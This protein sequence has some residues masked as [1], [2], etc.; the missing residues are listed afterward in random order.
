MKR[1]MM[2][3][4]L[5]S[6][7]LI[8]RN[9]EIT[10]PRLVGSLNEFLKRGGKIHVLDTGSTDKTAEVARKLGCN[11][12]EVGDKFRIKID[13]E[14]ADK[15][16]SKFVIEGEA[17]V[18]N[19]G[20]SLFDF[21]SARNYIAE[22]ADTDVISTPDCD[23]IFTKF[24]IDKLN[25]VIADGAEQLEYEFVF[26]H[27]DLGNPIIKFRHCKFY[28]RKK[29]KW[30]GVVHEVLG[31]SAKMVYLGEDIIKLEHY[32]NEKTNRSGYLKGL[33]IDCYQNPENDR[34]SHYFAR[35][36]MYLGRHK[37][38]IREFKNHISMNRWP[39]EAAQSMM[40]IGDC[41]SKLGDYDEMLKWY[42]KSVE[43]EVRRE[44][45]MR[46]AEYYFYRK[47]Y[48]QA[49]AY[50]EAALTVKQ[51]PFYSNHQPYYE[52]IPHALL[53][54]AYWWI[55]DKEKS[56]EHW[57][58]AL[59]FNPKNSKYI[60]DGKFYNINMPTKLDTYIENIKKNINF[61][62]TKRGDG[63]LNCMNGVVGKNCD[64][65]D[66]SK[67]LGERLKESFE[68]LKDKAD[69]LEW[70][71]QKNY[72]VL[73][74]RKDNNLEKLSEFYKAIKVSPRRKI[75]VGPKRLEK[76][77]D[78]L[79]AE[80]VEVPAVNAFEYIKGSDLRP[81]DN[82]IFIFSCGMPAKYLIAKTIKQN[83]NITCI[84]AGS[85]FDPIF[86][87]RTRTEQAD[88]QT[89]R[90]LYNLD[91]YND[92]KLEGMMTPTELEW[93][94][95]TSKTVDSFL[96]IGSYKG[97]STHAILSGGAKEVYA[98]DH[99]VGSSDPIETGN[100]DT[101]EAFLKNVGHFPNLKVKRMSSLEAVKDFEDKSL[102]VVFIDGGHRIQEITEDIIA[103]LPKAKKILCG[104]DYH[105]KKAVR[106]A[107]DTLLGPVQS[108]DRIWYKVLDGTEKL[109]MEKA[110][111]LARYLDMDL[112]NKM[113]ALP[114][115]NHP[116]KLFVI[117]NIES[118]IGKVIYDIGCGRNKTLKSAIGIDVIEG[119]DIVANADFLPMVKDESADII[120]SRH[121]IEHLPDTQRLLNEW[122]RILKPDG[123]IIFVL[124]DDKIINT[125]DPML[126][127]GCHFQAFTK[128]S[129][130]KE[131]QK[132]P[133]LKVEKIVNVVDGWSFG[134]VLVKKETPKMT[135]VIPTLGR[136]EGL[137][138]CLDSISNLYY[139][140]N[141]IEVIVKQDSFE[142]RTGVPK[143]LKQGVEESTGDWIVFGSNDTEFSPDSINEALKVGDKG[144]VSF[145]TG[146][147]L[148][149]G[150]NRN[151]HFMIRKDIVQKIGE[152][153]DT[154]YFHL[155]V[156][157]LLAAKMDKLG[158]FVRAEK[159]I[160]HHYHFTKPGGVF[161]EVYK[162][163]WSEEN[164]KHDR[165]LLKED[166]EKL[167]AK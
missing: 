19:E 85:A 18:V 7:C 160:V 135:F 156:D 48:P 60:E 34:N 51:L 28:N 4:P 115:E 73:L 117:E 124:P 30:H 120:I 35:E 53:Y 150:G 106:L 125:L 132:T 92:P 102:D 110:N 40:F 101:Y 114:Q 5:F 90:K 122:T 146:K 162:I 139:P 88:T 39:T 25:E 112:V 108:C 133:G 76:V 149:D 98:V 69:V 104:H 27:D 94:Y 59:S 54:V 131:V 155:G 70:T 93:L 79:G 107:V 154:R 2:N 56:K 140:K 89:L 87:G 72:N 74:H 113:F 20:E 116:E 57:D 165:E 97:K 67:E 63:E 1:K 143:L 161:D 167:N 75:F 151:E 9:E 137:K 119:S 23:E 12:I 78:F 8:A 166:L 26:S 128:D 86:F 44:P 134:G 36:M 65:H 13:K 164:I 138:R 11:V 66:Y 152:I 17:P 91:G 111:K 99:F 81:E 24:D 29:L 82:D 21:A 145:N 33:A 144:F 147:L 50:L 136:P 126:S 45:L 158:I 64:G 61:T 95:Q 15:V 130:S 46:L 68:F 77:C 42:S 109:D 105:D 84:D 3:K 14:L 43:K 157:N 83:P 71:D 16:N 80:F 58:K 142:N 103:W 52:D 100:L 153:F 32:Q 10:L 37:S 118:E 47:M 159:A 121:S 41:Y 55:G 22:F 163:A 49:I 129:F 123:K 127:A 62:V 38:A 31:G 148:P 96:E 6:V 141:K